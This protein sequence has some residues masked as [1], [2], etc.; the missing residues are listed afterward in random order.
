MHFTFLFYSP[1]SAY[2]EIDPNM[3]LGYNIR[4]LVPAS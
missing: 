1:L 3:S 4:I 2:K